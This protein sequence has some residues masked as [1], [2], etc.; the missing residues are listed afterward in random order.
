MQ[1][2]LRA[3]VN[4][5][6]DTL[7]NFLKGIPTVN[8]LREALR[9]TLL[10]HVRIAPSTLYQKTITN[11]DSD[12]EEQKTPVL[13]MPEWFDLQDYCFPLFKMSINIENRRT[14]VPLKNQAKVSSPMKDGLG[15]G[16]VK[17]LSRRNSLQPQIPPL[18][19]FEESFNQVCCLPSKIKL[20][21]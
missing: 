5:S 10:R 4:R 17:D 6:V 3:M 2:H 9:T 21:K 20:S 12:K 15:S 19:E 18:G 1:L 16:F 8:Q 7:F 14:A 11:T 13:G